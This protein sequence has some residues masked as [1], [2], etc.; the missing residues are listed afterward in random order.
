MSIFFSSLDKRSILIL[1]I[2]FVVV[3]TLGLIVLFFLNFFHILS[4]KPP[5]LKVIPISTSLPD[6]SL[7]TVSDIPGY[8]FQLKHPEQL[9]KVLNRWG[10]IGGINFPNSKG[11]AENTPVQKITFTL[12]EMNGSDTS[13]ASPSATISESKITI[14]KG[15]IQ[16]D[17]SLEKNQIENEIYNPQ[18]L[19]RI[20]L[21]RLYSLNHISNN[22]TDAKSRGENIIAAQKELENIYPDYFSIVKTSS[23]K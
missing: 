14:S 2:E 21:A 7:S 23:I 18:T 11:S 13:P 10:I 20:I 12:N 3:L 1:A 8:S 16:Y 4:P 15:T 19:L 22:D 6:S 9:A 17:F 5:T